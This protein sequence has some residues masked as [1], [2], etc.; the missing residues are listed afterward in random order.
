MLESAPALVHFP[1]RVQPGRFI[2]QSIPR[3]EDR[4]FVVGAGRYTDDFAVP[5][6]LNAAIVRSTYHAHARIRAIATERA[7]AA[8]GV[9]AVL[10]AADYLADGGRDIPHQPSPGDA[11]D[12]RRPAFDPA[13]GVL[14]IEVTQQV[15]ACE[16]VCHLGEPVAVVVAQT[17]AAAQDAAE[18]VD[19][20]YE[21][22]EAV[23]AA[24]DAM[25]PGATQLWP[26]VPGNV[27]LDARYGDEEQTARAF[28]QA[29]LVVEHEF[30]N[31]RVCAA[32][33]EP[34]A[35]VATYDAA[36]DVVSVVTGGQG[37]LRD[38]SLLAA[39][40]GLDR[41]RVEVHSPDVGGSFGARSHINPEAAIV[42]WA[43]RRLRRPVRWTATRSE[44]F[45]A[46]FQGRDFVVRAA[47]A[48]SADGT[49][50]GMRTNAISNAGAYTVNFSSPQNYVRI[51]PSVYHI[52]TATIHMLAVVTNTVPTNSYRGAGRPEAVHSIE[53]LLDIAARRLDLDRI[54]L[55]RR[56]LIPKAAL[57]YVTVTGLT[58]DAG[59]FSG[60]MDRALDECDWA[61]FPERRRAS[62]A[63][64][65]LRGIGIA[66]YVESPIGNPRERVAL[67]VL[68][69]RTVELVVGTQSS[70]QGHE[71]TFAQVVAD[72]L[73]VE[74]DA[75]RIV[76]GDTRRVAVG[77]GTQSDRS[78]R[79]VGTLLV[80]A[81]AKIR[82]RCAGT[83]LFAAAARGVLEASA[84]LDGR[85]PAFPTG[86]AVCELEID[87]ATGATTIVRYTQVD[88]VG[89]AINPLIVHG[90]THGGIAQGVGQA[91]VEGLPVDAETGQ[92]FGASFMSY[93]M[94]RAAD[95]P[96]FDVVL[97]E[98][99][100]A[101][102][103]LRVKGGGEGGTTPAPAAVSNAIA[104]ALA[105]LGI[106]D[107]PMPATA[108]KI[109]A[110]IDAAH[111]SAAG[112]RR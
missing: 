100:T 30:V 81:C 111:R 44:A 37:A 16:R 92:L 75:I 52:P 61:G 72:L 42:A 107:I 112:A 80:E 93:A 10:T 103:P 68:P 33:L 24:S 87:P 79:L 39:A 14:V 110:A 50:L 53:R 29:D 89:Q 47:L 35:A 94:P 31:Q 64:G 45:L 90:Q 36:R 13:A 11:I 102:N 12:P 70:G 2:G 99:P 82:E 77:G 46:D 41:E 73:D 15:L 17:A 69:E 48:L 63:R 98:D 97:V 9:V 32:H 19:V 8:S 106:E 56:N 67:R 86:C 54:E 34:R 84:D 109:W 43:A 96:S 4:R 74:L 49:I 62:A 104:D 71:T 101:G 27:C 65:L 25:R 108:P 76:T 88:D 57:P 59:D 22:L 38:R 3:L 23:L 6:A 18:L 55:R 28:A 40:L 21:P 1:A 85:V 105:E 20:T 91:L 51:Y 7:R 78:M 95:L 58:Y 60:N 66:N 5:G 83:D 26:H